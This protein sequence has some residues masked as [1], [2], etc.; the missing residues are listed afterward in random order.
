MVAALDVSVHSTRTTRNE[1]RHRFLGP[2]RN[3]AQEISAFLS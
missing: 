1:M 3:V 2:M